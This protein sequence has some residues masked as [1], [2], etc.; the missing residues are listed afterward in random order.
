MTN[1]NAL[2]V[3]NQLL[4]HPSVKHVYHPSTET[5]DAYND[6]KR[7]R[8]GGCVA[9]ML[10][11]DSTR[12]HSLR[13][14]YGGL[15]SILFHNDEC[16]RVFYNNLETAKGPGFG[17]NFTLVCP[18]TMIAHFNELEWCRNYSVD[19]SLVRVWVG[20]ESRSELTGIFSRALESVSQFP[21]E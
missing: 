10:S 9:P 7:A 17:S 3:V 16:A 6:F 8:V 13:C 4:A 15:F 2:A 5:T 1:A 11:H 20:L 19:P 14:R 21:E 18:Y 12:P